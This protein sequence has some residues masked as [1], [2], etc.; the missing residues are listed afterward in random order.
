MQVVGEAVRKPPLP[1]QKN[2]FDF[3][4]SCKN[5]ARGRAGGDGNARGGRGLGIGEADDVAGG[6]TPPI[7]SGNVPV[8]QYQQQLVCID[9]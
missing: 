2:V 9:S 1:R 8:H 3:S 4:G 5:T 7:S 6:G